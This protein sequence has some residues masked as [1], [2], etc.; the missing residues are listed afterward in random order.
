MISAAILL[1]LAITSFALYLTPTPVNRKSILH[2]LQFFLFQW[3]LLAGLFMAMPYILGW[4]LPLQQGLGSSPE[5]L[6]RGLLLSFACLFCI[7]VT[8]MQTEGALRWIKAL[9]L[10]LVGISEFSWV[11]DFMDSSVN[12]VLNASNMPMP[13]L[14]AIIFPYIVLLATYVLSLSLGG[15]FLISNTYRALKKA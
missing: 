9:L 4:K 12:G 3:M 13:A 15:V 7:V 1:F 5:L 2:F 11:W 6:L 10:L 14:Y 8:R